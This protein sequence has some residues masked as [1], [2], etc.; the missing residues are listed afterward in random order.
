M[1]KA[2][3][4]F[5][6]SLPLYQQ[7]FWGQGTTNLSVS[8]QPVVYTTFESH[9]YK[10]QKNWLPPVQNRRITHARIKSEMPT[11]V[12]FEG[13]FYQTWFT[14]LSRMCYKIPYLDFIYFF[15]NSTQQLYFS[16]LKLRKEKDPKVFCF[17]D[18]E[19]DIFFPLDVAWL[20]LP[21]G[22]TMLTRLSHKPVFPVTGALCWDCI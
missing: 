16:N 5:V 8:S 4:I 22:S 14:C 2:Y 10:I 15:L 21:G 13:D 17:K 19:M 9:G 6:K 18:K 11:F 3:Q 12:F 7:A 20:P 1:Q